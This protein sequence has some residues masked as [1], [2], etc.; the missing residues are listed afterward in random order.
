MP[1]ESNSRSSRTC[2]TKFVLELW[3]RTSTNRPRVAWSMKLLVSSLS[4][5]CKSELRTRSAA[6]RA[7]IRPVGLQPPPP[8]PP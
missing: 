3:S 5:V 7:D 4:S 6:T 8:P 1:D 2:V